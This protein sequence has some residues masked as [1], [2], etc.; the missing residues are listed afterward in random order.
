MFVRFK[1]MSGRERLA[2]IRI[3]QN[4]YKTLKCAILSI[5]S[6]DAYPRNTN[7]ILATMEVSNL[8]ICVMIDGL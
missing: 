1:E 2:E 4:P 6:C 8:K 7:H 3:L 5:S